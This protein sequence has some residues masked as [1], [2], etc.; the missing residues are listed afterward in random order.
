MSCKIQH[1]SRTSDTHVQN[2]QL[3]TRDPGYFSFGSVLVTRTFTSVNLHLLAQIDVHRLNVGVVVQGVLSQLATD[4]GSHVIDIRFKGG[5][6][7]KVRYVLPLCLKPPN[8]TL[9]FNVLT[10]LIQAVPAL[11]LWAVSNARLMSCV[12]T[13]AARP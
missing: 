4:C 13:A 7:E 9:G 11:S 12:K 5:Y 8:G 1:L 2:G 3:T 10:Q 6:R